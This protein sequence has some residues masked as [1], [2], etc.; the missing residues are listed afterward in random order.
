MG[1]I[2]IFEEKHNNIILLKSGKTFTDFTG[3]NTLPN[4][5]VYRNIRLSESIICWAVFQVTALA[6]KYG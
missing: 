4:A 5:R 1:V 6:S 3:T 2:L